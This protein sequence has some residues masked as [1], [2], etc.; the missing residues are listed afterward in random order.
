MTLQD[1]DD[2]RR[3]LAGMVAEVS[4][5]EVTAEQVLASPHPLAALGVT[6]ITQIRLIDAVEVAFGIDVDLDGDL[7]FLDNVDSLADYVRARAAP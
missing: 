7:R 1:R 3:T 6:S 4:E 2:L 5:G